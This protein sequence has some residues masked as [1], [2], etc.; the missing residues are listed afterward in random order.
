MIPFNKPYL[1]GKETKYIEDA[2]WTGKI[3]GNGRCALCPSTYF[4]VSWRTVQVA[5]DKSFEFQNILNFW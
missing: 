1:T 5:R 2:V 3:S 4:S